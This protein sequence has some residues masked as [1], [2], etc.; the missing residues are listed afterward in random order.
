MKINKV[1]LSL[2]VFASLFSACDDKIDHFEYEG[3][4]QKAQTVDVSKL[5]YDSLPGSIKLRWDTT[6]IKYEYMKVS[7]ID[8]S[9]QKTVTAVVSKYCDSL[10]V[11]NTLRKYGDYDFSFQA[12]NSLNK[13]GSIV[14]FKARS[15][16]APAVITVN[17]TKV[18]LTVDQL[19]TNDQE[20][21]EGPIGNLIDNNPNTFFH[22]RWSSPQK[23]LPQYIQ[24]DFKEDHE[25][26][27]IWYKNRN[28]SQVG[29][30][31]FDLQISQDGNQWET[32]K[33]VNS[34]LPSAS[35]AEYTSDVVQPGKKF[36][37][38]RLNVTKTFGDRNYFNMA[39][40]AFYD[41]QVLVN[42]PEAK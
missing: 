18:N 26:F 7:Y 11:E 30:Q 37:Y 20:P 35:G 40:L 6:G 33:T 14:T 27:A 2:V 41:A 38:F 34:G 28:G 29:P 5:S 23:P 9:D 25:D 12:F 24:I 1:L 10:L 13:G 17:K 15:G 19:S 4:T 8:P 3:Y 21:S 32:V 31:S 22:T 16:R 36:R 42:D 39:E